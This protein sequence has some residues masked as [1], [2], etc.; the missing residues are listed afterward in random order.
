MTKKE[1]TTVNLN[2]RQICFLDEI[3]KKSKFSGGRKLSRTAIL[4]AILKA[5]NKLDIDVSGIKTEKELKERL[6]ESFKRRG[7]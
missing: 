1:W 2:K 5:A 6:L 7:K 3:S 4:R